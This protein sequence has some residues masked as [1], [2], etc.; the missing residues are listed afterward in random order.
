M[1]TRLVLSAAG[2]AVGFVVTGGNPAGAQVGWAIGGI[3][4]GIVDPDKIYGP[5][6][7]DARTQTARDGVPIPIVY[8]TAAVSGSIIWA[9]PLVETEN[10]DNG[11]GGPVSVTYTYQRSYAIMICEGP[12]I[13]VRRVWQDEKLVYDI[14]AGGTI[15]DKAASAYFAANATFYLG[16]ESQTA[17]STI[18]AIE[19][20]GNVP[21]HRGTA[22]MVMELDDLTER[23]GS[24]PNYRFEVVT[25]GTANENEQTDLTAPKVGKFYDSHWPLANS[26]DGYTFTGNM[27]FQSEYAGSS[28]QDVIDHFSTLTGRDYSFYLGYS[29]DNASSAL[30]MSPYFYDEVAA[31]PTVEYQAHDGVALVYNCKDP[32]RYLNI[33]SMGYCDVYVT[34]SASNPWSADKYGTVFRLV[35]LSERTS[36]YISA[37]TAYGLQDDGAFPVVEEFYALI[38]RVDR[39]SYCPVAAQNPVGIGATTIP[40]ADGFEIDEDG[41]VNYYREWEY[42][43]NV[44]G[45]APYVALNVEGTTNSANSVAW[46]TNPIIE[47]GSTNDNETWWT[48]RYNEAVAAGIVQSGWTYGV[49]YPDDCWDACVATFTYN[50]ITSNTFTLADIV[51]DLCERA[52][53]SASDID[54]TE[55]TDEVR[56]FVVGRA[57]TASDAIQPLMPAYLFDAGEWD[58]KIN[59]IK[60]GGSSVKTLTVDDLVQTDGPRWIETRAQEAE[61]PRKMNVI[62]MSP[63]ANYV[64]TKQTAERRSSNISAVGE[65]SVELPIVF[66]EDEAAQV[67]DKLLKTTWND[68]LGSI[69]LSVS[70]EHSD[71]TATDIITFN[72]GTRSTRLRIEQADEADGVIKLKCRQ[73]RVSAYSSSVV[74]VDPTTDPDGGGVGGGPVGPTRFVVIDASPLRQSDDSLGVY[75]AACGV[76]S[77]WYGCSVQYSIDDGATWIEAGQIRTGATIGI[78]TEQVPNASAYVF[79]DTNTV[80]VSMYNGTLSTIT[81]ANFLRQGNR[82]ALVA[83]GDSTGYPT[84]EIFQYRTA[85]ATGSGT[86]DLT[87]LLRWRQGGEVFAS[88]RPAGHAFVYL[89]N[90][91]TLANGVLYV[92]FSIGALGRPLANVRIK[93]VSLG[94]AEGDNPYIQRSLRYPASMLEWAP[95]FVRG[96]INADESVSVSWIGRGRNG[97]TRQPYNSQ[98]FEGYE[99]RLSQY[100]APGAGSDSYYIKRVVWDSSYNF[101]ASEITN[102]SAGET[103]STYYVHVLPV[104]SLI[105]VS[106][107]HYDSALLVEGETQPSPGPIFSDGF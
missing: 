58:G 92:P 48:A 54:V 57:T 107:R 75:V 14:T 25:E 71:L 7:Q 85:T 49:E 53:L 55:L 33:D 67:A 41:N 20:V 17:D 37:C 69:D 19:G 66:D 70:Y 1:S 72:S 91:E 62:Y 56:G 52:G 45:T 11:K 77:G 22:Y 43:E 24:I 26:H 73:E 84:S 31:Q 81:D 60:R 39:V 97:S 76:L 106:L 89:G 64:P 100:P 80:S 27:L 47:K 44:S 94:T 18:E 21:A 95:Q 35:K 34:P 65:V 78:L 16:D 102:S 12:I 93:C 51:S 99:V 42:E 4:G 8:G 32:V 96:Q 38:I 36:Q 61:Y 10:E 28:L 23:G 59:F 68:L 63:D 82:C 9:G 50:D 98:W 83:F 30:G 87:H 29:F 101:S 74:G 6:L 40:G 46:I 13:G 104:N 105:G 103:K 5:K 15:A 86:Y 2:A 90:G 88:D 3:V 79:D